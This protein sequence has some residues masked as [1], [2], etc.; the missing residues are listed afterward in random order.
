MGV[1]FAIPTD[2]LWVYLIGM[3]FS[4]VGLWRVAQSRR[5]LARDQAAIRSAGSSLDLTQALMTERSRPVGG[6]T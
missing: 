6:S 2:T 4:L 1:A 3:A 5:T